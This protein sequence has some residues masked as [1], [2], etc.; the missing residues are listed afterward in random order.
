MTVVGAL[1]VEKDFAYAAVY[2]ENRFKIASEKVNEI[3]YKY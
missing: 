2:G 3:Y 1:V